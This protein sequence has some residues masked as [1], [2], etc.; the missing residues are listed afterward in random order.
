MKKRWMVIASCVLATS[1][2]AGSAFAKSETNNANE[3]KS[4]KVKVNVDLK[5]NA[6]LDVTVTSDTYGNQG[7]NGYKGLL[8]AINN[9]K[10]K[11]AGAVIADLLLTK[12]ETQLT[13]E[14]KAELEAIKEK[15]AALS[16]FADLL[17]RT[18][19]VTDAV[20]VQKEAIIANVTNLD[21]YKKLGKL[22]DK[23]GKKGVKLYVNG[24]EPTFEVAPFIRE[25]NTLVPFRA[26]SEALKATVTWNEE[27]RSVTVTRGGITVKLF[28]DSKTATV[29][30]N[31]VTLEV[32][33][34]IENGSTVV[35]VRFVSEA[36][37]AAVKWESETQSVV[38]YED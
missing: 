35:P 33:A 30:G 7:H 13:A 28:I 31:E 2:M 5:V 1:L 21:S 20:Y 3:G 6:K 16:E 9:V 25:G 12:Y 8:N 37:K 23:L 17:D 32:P 19:S 15:D 29:N 36:L 14:M 24:E 22:Y 10:D 27:E 38:I 26:I 34:A 11:P 4:D 18:G